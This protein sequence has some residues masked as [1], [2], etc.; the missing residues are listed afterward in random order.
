MIRFIFTCMCIALVWY[1]VVTKEDKE[2]IHHDISAIDQA[3]AKEMGT[4]PLVAPPKSKNLQLGGGPDP[5]C[6]VGR[7]IP[8]KDPKIGHIDM[9]YCEQKTQE[10]CEV[11]RKRALKRGSPWDIDCVPNPKPGR[12]IYEQP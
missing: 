10:A 11:T 9:Y 4:Q 7:N 2:A 5:W 6:T 3:V 12:M 8:A 1:K